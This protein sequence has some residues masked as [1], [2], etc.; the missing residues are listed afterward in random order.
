MAGSRP[1][2]RMSGLIALAATATP[3]ISPP[4]PMGTGST[5]RSG[6]VFQH[7]QGDGAL[8]GHDLH[9]VERMHEHHL[10]VAPI[11]DGVVGRFV[12][13]VGV[14]HHVRAEVA[15]LLH[16]HERGRARH[17]DGDGNAKAR[18]V[19]GEALRMIAGGRGDH[20]AALFGLGEL[21]QL[22]QGAALFVGGRELLV[23][24]LHPH[25]RAGDLGQGPRPAHRGLFDVAVQP[26]GGGLDQFKG[27]VHWLSR[28][29]SR[30]LTTAGHKGNVERGQ[31]GG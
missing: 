19:I 5:S 23:L 18:T 9:V 13:G 10:P 27:Q 3:E 7:F 2:M 31:A 30:N 16:L 25:V 6:A 15:G 17:D 4:P 20:A 26:L 29:K 28:K 12:E 21:Q 14:Q 22:V 1:T 11:G 24:E 8:A